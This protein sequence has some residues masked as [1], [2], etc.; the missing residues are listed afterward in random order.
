MKL[1][2]LVPFLLITIMLCT[3]AEPFPPEPGPAASD[4]EEDSQDQLTPSDYRLKQS[5][6]AYTPGVTLGSL[7]RYILESPDNR[8][9]TFTT[10]V[11]KAMEDA[12][13]NLPRGSVLCY[14]G[15]PLIT[16]PSETQIQA[17]EAI[18]KK[19]HIRCVVNPTS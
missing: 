19:K 2:F 16:P 1:T 17:L 7:T 14:D 9:Q 8:I 12:I 4:A 18:C 10:F 5:Q 6:G 11:S 3:I 13:G 15:H